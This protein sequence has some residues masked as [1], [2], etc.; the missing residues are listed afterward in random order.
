M[1]SF[2]GPSRSA[3]AD[4]PVPIRQPLLPVRLVLWP[5]VSAA[6]Y[7][8]AVSGPCPPSFPRRS[9]SR[10]SACRRGSSGA[11]VLGRPPVIEGKI[12]GT[13]CANRT[14]VSGTGDYVQPTTARIRGQARSSR[15]PVSRRSRQCFR[16]PVFQGAGV[17]GGRCLRGPVSQ[18]AGVSGPV[19]EDPRAASLASGVT[20][21]A[22]G[23][24]REAGI[25]VPACSPARAGLRQ[26]EE[27]G[28]RHPTAVVPSS[29]Q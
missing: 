14:G 3:D 8:G 1:R 29:P 2:A 25:A 9:A 6:G 21:R 28:R 17:S 18:G 7:R 27:L 20:G 19:F 23:S 16:E 22:P 12:F 10:R 5:L 13:S 15:G 26:P 11:P 24:C 4:L